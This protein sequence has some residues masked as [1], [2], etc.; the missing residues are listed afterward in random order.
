M[1]PIPESLQ[2]LTRLSATTD[3][4]LVESL[5]HTAVRVVEA[6]PDCV[7]I[8]I[9]N[10]RA[11]LTFTLLSTAERLR[12][13]DAAQY[14][15]GGPCQLAALDGEEVT[16]DDLL[17]E[18]QWQLLA[19]A[20]AAQGVKSSLSLPMRHLGQLYGSVN[21]Y[22]SSTYGFQGREQ[23]LARMFGAATEEAVANADLS[24][25]S[26]GRARQAVETLD[27]NDSIQQAVGMLAVRGG[28]TVDEA[29]RRLDEAADRAGIS[30]VTLAELVLRGRVA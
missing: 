2:A 5:R 11:D 6:I 9:C 7:G 1:E 19:L 18:D 29:Q 14:L 13:L 3:T 8:S 4:D 20:S 10:F 22:A 27:A 23:D 15:D 28:V 30:P 24:M 26:L 25:S 16:V 21:F 12:I 17:D